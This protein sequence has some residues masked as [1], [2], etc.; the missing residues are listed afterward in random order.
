MGV[1]RNL[2]SSYGFAVQLDGGAQEST[3]RRFGGEL[4]LYGTLF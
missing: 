2:V 3:F 1:R 4:T